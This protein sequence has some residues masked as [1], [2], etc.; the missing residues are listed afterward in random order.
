[1]SSSFP[2]GLIDAKRS[3]VAPVCITVV[4]PARELTPSNL[5]PTHG[6]FA[7]GAAST[8]HATRSGEFRSLR[9][10]RPGDPPRQ[11][12]WP[13]STRRRGLVLRELESTQPRRV[14]ILFHTHRPPRT[15]L[16][17][18]VFESALELLHGVILLVRKQ[19]W[20]AEFWADFTHAPRPVWL[21]SGHHAELDSWLAEARMMDSP[22][23]ELPLALATDEKSEH[24]L[25]IVISNTPVRYW[26]T[27]FKAACRGNL[28][29]L[30]PQEAR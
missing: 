24:W 9:D 17:S 27:Q 10:Y 4:P 28:I 29:C 11:I 30:D 8:T 7:T 2:L 22:S 13:A 5:V 12:S 19:G 6:T 18:K 23:L 21:E 25:T 20:Q 15:V 3:G 16:H 1:M 14:R 26:M